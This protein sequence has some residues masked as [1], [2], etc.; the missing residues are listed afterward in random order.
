MAEPLRGQLEKWAADYVRLW[1]EGDKEGW[2]QNWRDVAPGDF[3][4]WDPVGTPP[5]YGFEHCAVDSFDLFR[6]S[7]EFHT[8]KE[9]LFFNRAHV[10]WVMQNR[11]D[12]NGRKASVNSIET[13]EF[14][15]DGSVVIRTFYPVPSH[16]DEA[17]GDLFKTYLPAGGSGPG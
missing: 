9:T 16:D 7:V 2:K 17:L 10:A 11:F 12:R 5:K 4:M 3:T 1:N 8:P 15:A 13:F 14:G 6:P